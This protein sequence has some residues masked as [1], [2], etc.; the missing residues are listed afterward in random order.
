MWRSTTSWNQI[1]RAV[2]NPN[3]CAW[4]SFGCIMLWKLS[5]YPLEFIIN[6][7]LRGT[8]HIMFAAY[9]SP[10]FE[11]TASGVRGRC[12]IWSGQVFQNHWIWCLLRLAS[13]CIRILPSTRPCARFD[14]IAILRQVDIQGLLRICWH[15]DGRGGHADSIGVSAVGDTRRNIYTPM[16]FGA[17]ATKRNQQDIRTQFY[18]CIY[19]SVY[20]FPGFV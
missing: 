20:I 3:R 10:R 7:A 1:Q 4:S 2:S 15:L 9:R 16:R 18:Q 12:L 19:P 14:A 6:V 5:L 17:R 11:V 13:L 8:L